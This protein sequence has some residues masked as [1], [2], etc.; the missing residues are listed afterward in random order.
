DKMYDT[1]AVYQTL[2]DHFPNAEIVIPPKDNTF[3]DEVNHP[4]RMSNLS[5][6]YSVLILNEGIL[7]L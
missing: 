1:N 4:K 7:A 2:E 5:G 3:A 6:G